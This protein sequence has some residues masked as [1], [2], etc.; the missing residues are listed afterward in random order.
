L[1]KFGEMLNDML[2]SVYH[3]ILRV[4]EDF[5]TR[6][7]GV[8][9]T[10]REMHLIEHVGKAGVEGRTLSEIADFLEVARP[11]VT[12]SVQKLEQKGFLTKT[13][14]PQDGRVVHVT[15]TREGRKI[16]IH[17]MRF[18]IFMV[19]ELESELGEEEKNVL[20][21]AIKKLDK[22]FEKSIEA[23]AR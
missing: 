13:G 11:S 9:I 8:G 2:V 4:E 15:L 21:H 19:Q 17:H 23:S 16:F 1:Q 7:V 10:I 20:I 6:G 18:H 3:K 5:L 14:C 12:V 22:Y